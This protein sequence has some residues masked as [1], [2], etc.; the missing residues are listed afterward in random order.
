MAQTMIFTQDLPWISEKYKGDKNT[1]IRYKVKKW[2]KN[3]NGEDGIARLFINTDES[4]G[5][6]EIVA[7]LKGKN[8]YFE[9]M[10]EAMKTNPLK[11]IT[12]NWQ[13]DIKDEFGSFQRFPYYKDNVTWSLVP[14][15]GQEKYKDNAEYDMFR[16]IEEGDFQNEMEQFLYESI[17]DDIHTSAE[18][19]QEEYIYSH[20]PYP[21]GWVTL[22][23]ENGYIIEFPPDESDDDS[24]EFDYS[25]PKTFTIDDIT[26]KLQLKKIISG[27]TEFTLDELKTMFELL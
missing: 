8:E 1:A 12:C 20:S 4:K 26:E 24:S 10:V 5:P 21:E 2:L 27:K 22:N 18:S 13:R 9:K 23:E 3:V 11:Q 25:G 17:E 7:T 14:L 19:D 15:Y 16:D 6:I